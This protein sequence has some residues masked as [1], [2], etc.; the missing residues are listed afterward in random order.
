MEVLEFVLERTRNSESRVRIA[1][2]CGQ[3]KQCMTRFLLLLFQLEADLV[4]ARTIDLA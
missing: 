3:D 4:I 2:W 1:T